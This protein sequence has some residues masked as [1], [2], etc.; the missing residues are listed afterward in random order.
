[1]VCGPGLPNFDLLDL[2]LMFLARTSPC[3]AQIIRQLTDH[4]HFAGEWDFN[5]DLS[6][7]SERPSLAAQH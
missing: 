5:I 2:Y 1:M 4:L 3:C 7:A 6:P